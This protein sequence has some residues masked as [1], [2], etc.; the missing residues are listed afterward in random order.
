METNIF[1]MGVI[2]ITPNSF[3]D[4][5]KSFALDTFLVKW[6]KLLEQGV[7]IID[8]GAESTAPF[9][10]P[11]DEIKEKE[12]FEKLFFP[13]LG[14]LKMPEALSI[15]TYRP[16]VFKYVYHEV[17]RVF[18]NQKFIFNDVSGIIDEKLWEVL[19]EC[20]DVDYVLGH[21]LIKD[22][23]DTSGHM[24]KLVEGN[25]LKNLEEHFR[26]GYE[27]FVARK[28][29]HRLIFDPLFGFSKTM[30]QNWQLIG[31]LP[32]LVKSF[33]L[34]QRWLLGISKKSF[35]HKKVP[36]NLSK[37]EILSYSELIHSN[38]LSRWMHQLRDHQLI[39]RVH[40][41]MVVSISRLIENT[42]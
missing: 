34:K 5:G 31:D 42:L 14:T 40:D 6:E 9:N 4:G 33:P 19:G 17:K 12:R 16:M 24:E 11:V 25:L 32:T 37:E 3:S 1:T 13:L 15:D 2:N 29:E 41:P 36:Q 8:L 23:F 28:M 20:H 18:P 38:I 27:E 35:L 39:F 21:T 7:S 30:E 22:R 26:A 10:D